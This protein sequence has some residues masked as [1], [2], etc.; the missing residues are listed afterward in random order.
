CKEPLTLDPTLEGEEF[1]VS[2]NRKK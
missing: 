2:Y 1:D